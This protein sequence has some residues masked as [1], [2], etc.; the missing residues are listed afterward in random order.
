MNLRNARHT[1]GNAAKG[2]GSTNKFKRILR[3]AGQRK[4]VLYCW[5]NKGIGA[6]DLNGFHLLSLLAPCCTIQ[7]HK[8]FGKVPA[9][10]IV[11]QRRLV[12]YLNSSI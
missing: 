7:Q 6:L 9:D 8:R 10:A 3:P 5:F 11:I 2:C 4:T 1:E 12:P